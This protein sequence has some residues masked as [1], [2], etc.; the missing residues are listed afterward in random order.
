MRT[1]LQLTAK[2]RDLLV[3]LNKQ[4]AGLNDHAQSRIGLIKMTADCNSVSSY[5]HGLGV[6]GFV[7]FTD[8]VEFR[9]WINAQTDRNHPKFDW[10]FPQ[11]KIGI[12]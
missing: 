12:I 8:R 7:L 6:M 1:S 11:G 2:I 9:P 3:E 5:H 10:N 4:T